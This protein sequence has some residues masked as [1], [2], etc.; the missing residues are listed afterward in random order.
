MT[1]DYDFLC[2]NLITHTLVKHNVTWGRYMYIIW[3]IQTYMY[4]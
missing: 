3:Y 1:Y 2:D 4:M